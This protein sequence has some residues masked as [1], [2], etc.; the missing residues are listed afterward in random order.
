MLQP[1]REITLFWQDV[2]H[3][4]MEDPSKIILKEKS[5]I[6]VNKSLPLENEIVEE[7][8]ITLDVYLLFNPK[9]IV[10]VKMNKQ[11]FFL[12]V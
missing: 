5:V 7:P 1:P 3:F 6:D 10:P 12:Q 11:I 4:T 9:P 8:E 2:D